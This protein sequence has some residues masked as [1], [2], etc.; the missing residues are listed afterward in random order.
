MLNDIPEEAKG[1]IA[2]EIGEFAFNKPWCSLNEVEQMLCTV[3]AD[4]I[5]DLLITIITKQA[6]EDIDPQAEL[7]VWFIE[8]GWTPPG[9][10]KNKIKEAQEVQMPEGK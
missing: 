4:R 2:H 5:A 3:R 10:L 8:H 6:Q 1:Q 9:E 7:F